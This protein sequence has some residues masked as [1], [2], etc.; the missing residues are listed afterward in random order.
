[1][2]EA[3]A[4]QMADAGGIGIARMLEEQGAKRIKTE[5]VQSLDTAA[6]IH[7]NEQDS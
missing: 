1:M 7:I 2:S 5:A 4:S 6:A 3:I